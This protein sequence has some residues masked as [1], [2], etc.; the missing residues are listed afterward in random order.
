[1]LARGLKDLQGGQ[2]PAFEAK[3]PAG[4]GKGGVPG[5][6]VVHAGKTVGRLHFLSQI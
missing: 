4:T 6:L 3:D 2:I 5:N 1:M